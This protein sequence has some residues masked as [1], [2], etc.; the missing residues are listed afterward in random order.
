MGI[1]LELIT[2]STLIFAILMVA[3][4]KPLKVSYV[5]KEI[6]QHKITEKQRFEEYQSFAKEL[7]EV[8]INFENKFAAALK[9]KLNK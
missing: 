9:G 2:F 8:T 6:V 7:E 4:F 5:A 1:E 3:C